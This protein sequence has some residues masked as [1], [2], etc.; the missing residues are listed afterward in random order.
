MKRTL[1][2]WL[3][4]TALATAVGAV[5]YARWLPQDSQVGFAYRQMGVPLQGR[6]ARIDAQITFD[7]QR[8]EA[9]RAIVEVDVASIDTGLAEA[10][11]TALSRDW[12]DAKTHPKARFVSTAVRPLGAD[13]YEVSGELTIKGRTR[14]VSAPF[15]VRRDGDRAV[16]TGTFVL[17]RLQFGIG[18]GTWADVS[19]VADEVEVRFQLAAAAAAVPVHRKG[20]AK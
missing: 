9:G 13:R 4:L 1:G 16:L 7:P 10:N 6:F 17:K 14:A 19:A 18:E 8:P 11:D 20:N 3:L 12:F 15:T 5:E 2:S